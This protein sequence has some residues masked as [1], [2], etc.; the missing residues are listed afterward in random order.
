MRIALI[1]ESFFP[2]ISGLTVSLYCRLKCFSQWGHEVRLYAP[3]YKVLSHIYPNYKDYIG[4]ILP[5]ITVIPYPS[6]KFMNFDNLCHPKPLTFDTVEEDI[7]SFKPDIINLESSEGLFVGFW[8]RAG[9]NAAKKLGIP[10]TSLYHTNWIAYF[11][12]YKKQIPLLKIPGIERVFTKLITWINNSY[13]LTLVPSKNAEQFLKQ[14]GIKN[15]HYGRFLGIDVSKFSPY[16]KQEIKELDVL[17]DKI[18]VLY[19]GRL[20]PDK[21]IDTLLRVFD[22]TRKVTDKCGFVI[23]GCGSDEERVKSWASQYSDTVFIGRIPNEETPKYYSACD[24]FITASNKENH[25][26]TVWE[27]MASGLPVVGPN[28]RG[29]GELVYNNKTGILVNTGAV[30]E[31][32]SAILRL[33]TDET[34]RHKMSRNALNMVKDCT[35]ENAAQNQLN[36][37]KDL[38]QQKSKDTQ[39]SI[40]RRRLLG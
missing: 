7:M 40:S 10:I 24:I 5:N 15:T 20:T 33:S 28:E 38:I 19:I 2:E 3:S 27:A 4:E 21:Q 12:D 18:K 25:P 35:W 29:V 26:L 34:L 36:V 9:L 31:F 17:K 30:D 14:C 37:W 23:V 13:D 22:E 6:K 39:N 1:T 16:Q 8:E 11:S 32:V